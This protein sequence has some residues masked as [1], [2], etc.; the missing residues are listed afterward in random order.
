MTRSPNERTRALF[1]LVS[2]RLEAAETALGASL[3]RLAALDAEIAGLVIDRA[4]SACVTGEERALGAIELQRRMALSRIEELRRSRELIEAESDRLRD[5]TRR[6][7]R[8]KI[9][10]EGALSAAAEEERRRARNQ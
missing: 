3:R 4:R 2:K 8:Q 1:S 7:L 5:E 6:F 9:A 10:L